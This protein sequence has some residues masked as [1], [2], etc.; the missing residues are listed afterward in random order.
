VANLVKERNF[1]SSDE[2]DCKQT[3]IELYSQFE[4]CL[5]E[6][7]QSQSGFELEFFENFQEIRRGIDKHRENAHFQRF[8]AKTDEISLS[9]IDRTHDFEKRY[10]ISLNNV[11]KQMQ[12]LNPLA[13]I[14]DTT[15]IFRL[16]TRRNSFV[17]RPFK[18]ESICAK[19][20]VQ[21]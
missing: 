10:F 11:I 16:V 17:K 18:I 7:S 20:D 3:I 2:H 4:Q 19:F 15:S 21:G 13:S 12:P 1:L 9:M 8:K 6:L 14:K 5:D